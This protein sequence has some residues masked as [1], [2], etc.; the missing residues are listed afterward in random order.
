MLK[1]VLHTIQLLE[2][3]EQ[4]SQEVKD[5]I[6]YL[7]QTVQ[8]KT[9]AQLLDLM[10]VGDVLGYDNLQKS[11]ERCAPIFGGYE[12]CSFL[13]SIRYLLLY[14]YNNISPFSNSSS[15]FT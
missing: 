5:A 13:A 6:D 1:E 15:S 12:E 2:K 3:I 8:T 4:P 10:T 14:M 11:L 7:R 9:N